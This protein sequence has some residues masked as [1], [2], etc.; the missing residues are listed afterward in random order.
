MID[1]GHLFAAVE[2]SV[3]SRDQLHPK[4]VFLTE[5]V[6]V[7]TLESGI[8]LSITY[9]LCRIVY[10]RCFHPLAKVPGPWLASVTRAVSILP[11]ASLML[12]LKTPVHGDTSTALSATSH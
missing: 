7:T 5:A 11:T 3:G 1:F 12:E 4:M 6:I 9:V 8:C 2:M 10:T